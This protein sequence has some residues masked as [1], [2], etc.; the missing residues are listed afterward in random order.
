MPPAMGEAAGQ[1]IRVVPGDARLSG[2]DLTGEGHAW[3][4]AR[5]GLQWVLLDAT[6]DA[7]RASR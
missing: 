7:W 4:A 1:E 6:W 3:N 5:V 2:S